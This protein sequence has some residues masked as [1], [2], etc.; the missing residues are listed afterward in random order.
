MPSK[1]AK[2]GVFTQSPALLDAAT[3]LGVFA[4][5][6]CKRSSIWRPLGDETFDRALSIL[7]GPILPELEFRLDLIDRHLECHNPAHHL[8]VEVLGQFFCP[9]RLRT[10]TLIFS[11]ESLK[12]ARSNLTI[13]CRERPTVHVD[14]CVVPSWNRRCGGVPVWRNVPMG[15]LENSEGLRASIEISPVSI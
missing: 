3:Y 5:Q 2:F 9:V 7:L 6:G 11:D 1:M 14:Y 12:D 15:T 13:L 4:H 10:V 8:F